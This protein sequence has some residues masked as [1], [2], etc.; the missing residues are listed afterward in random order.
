MQ[1]DKTKKEKSYKRGI[2]AINSSCA[3]AKNLHG[4]L[5]WR[6]GHRSRSKNKFSNRNGN[7]NDKQMEYK[8]VMQ[9]YGDI[10]YQFVKS[11]A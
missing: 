7:G 9:V 6:Y 5:W 1:S 11:Y 8:Y 4:L 3:C 2:P 10:C